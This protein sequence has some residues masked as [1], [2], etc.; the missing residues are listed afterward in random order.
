LQRANR[1]EKVQEE[2]A[3][4]KE[5]MERNLALLT[6]EL[7]STRAELDHTLLQ[8]REYVAKAAEMQMEIEFLTKASVQSNQQLGRVL[9]QQQR[10]THSTAATSHHLQRQQQ[11]DLEAKVTALT[12]WALASA[13]AKQLA[14]EHAKHLE[15]KVHDLLEQL[16]QH[17]RLLALEDAGLDTSVTNDTG[18]TS[19][20]G[21]RED[22]TPLL[23]TQSKERKLWSEHS[24]LVIGAGMERSYV[25][26]F[27]TD[28]TVLEGE[29]IVVR[30]KFDVTPSDMDIYFSM[31]KGNYTENKGWESSDPLIKNRRVLGGGG[32]DIEGAFV[33]QNACTLVWSNTHSWIRPRTIKFL[34]DVFAITE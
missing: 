24:S 8:Q 22:S 19:G 20:S 4:Q 29:I 18:I 31:Y 16:E 13:E 21:A 33:I 17:Q 14:V 10:S 9:E 30:W 11:Q 34:L 23:V 32:G 26:E 5:E 3:N 27:R 25:L 2:M 28:S 12:E 7:R 6:A 15:H 1:L